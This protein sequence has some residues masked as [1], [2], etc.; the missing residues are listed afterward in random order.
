MFDYFR[1]DDHNE[2][3]AISNNKGFTKLYIFFTIGRL[4]IQF[5]RR[6]V[7]ELN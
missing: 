1:P 6:V 2:V 7:K 4:K 3:K 5:L